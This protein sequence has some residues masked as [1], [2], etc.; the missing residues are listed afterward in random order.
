[1]RTLSRFIKTVFS[2]LLIGLLLLFA[3]NNHASAVI[4]LFPLPF[5]A[6][7]PLFLL[8]ALA[9]ACGMMLAALLMSL[10][11]YGRRK[12]TREAIARADALQNEVEA[13][14]LTSPKS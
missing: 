6:E 13:L 11:G 7:M 9:F 10:R 8:V 3:A 12:E 5:E 14:K 4:S 1:M 2:V